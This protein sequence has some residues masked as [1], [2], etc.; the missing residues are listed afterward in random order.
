MS[1]VSVPTMRAVSCV[2]VLQNVRVNAT[3]EKR[4]QA[5]LDGQST[6]LPWTVT[7]FDSSSLKIVNDLNISDP[8]VWRKMFPKGTIWG[9]S[10]F[11]N[12]DYTLVNTNWTN[13][14]ELNDDDI[15]PASGIASN[16]FELLASYERSQGRNATSVLDVDELASATIAVYGLFNAELLSHFRVSSQL[17]DEGAQELTQAQ[18]HTLQARVKPNPRTTFAVVG[19]L[20]VVLAL[21]LL[22]FLT[23]SSEN[24]LLGE[25][26][27]ISTQFSLFAGSKVVERLRAEDSDAVWDEKFSLGWW[28]ARGPN[29]EDFRWGIDIGKLDA[30]TQDYD[31]LG[32][33][34]KR[35]S[36]STMMTFWRG[37]LARKR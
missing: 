20:S 19:M 36:L 17:D 35:R 32:P 10:P 24:V 9:H 6:I 3:I 2:P 14:S 18:L 7:D 28:S 23:T 30:T 12:R 26:S 37:K 33:S 21:L 5:G 1:N 11:I 15:R 34:K 25:P 31:S 16:F 8:Q 4:V 27:K 22:I 13:E 29:G